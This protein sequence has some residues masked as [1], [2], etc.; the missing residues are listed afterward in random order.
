[1]FNVMSLFGSGKSATDLPGNRKQADQWLETLPENDLHGQQNAIV[2]L[3]RRLDAEIQNPHSD[4]VDTL[5]VIDTIDHHIQPLQETLTQQYL[6]SPRLAPQLEN[7]LWTAIFRYYDVASRLYLN[8]LH[9]AQSG[10]QPK[11]G[12]SGLAQKLCARGLYNLGNAFKLKFLR[13]GSPDAEMW[14]ILHSF[15]MSAETGGYEKRMTN[16]YSNHEYSCTSLYLRVEM[17]AMSHPGSLSPEQIE[18]IDKWLL[19][20]TGDISIDRNPRPGRHHYFIDL[21]HSH[22]ALP[23]GAT[24]YPDTC[25]GWD[26]STLILQLQRTRASLIQAKSTG[27]VDSANRYRLVTALEY[28]EKQWNPGHLGKL[29]KF[30]RNKSTRQIATVHGLADLCA[31]VHGQES[32]TDGVNPDTAAEIRYTETVD[33]QMYGFITEN[34]KQRNSQLLGSVHKPLPAPDMWDTENESQN[35]YLI[36]FPSQHNS[37]L[38]LGSLIGALDPTDHQWRVCV[39]RRLI[40]TQQPLSMAGIQV[41]TSSPMVLLLQPLQSESRSGETSMRLTSSRALLTTPIQND[42]FTLIL[43][44]S[45][46][47]KSRVYKFQISPTQPVMYFRLGRVLEKGDLWIHTEALL[48]QNQNPTDPTQG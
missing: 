46:Y 34:T 44:S 42:H 35:G 6:R 3:L 33:L 11:S 24:S 10:S 15:F 7:K 27:G 21:A 18:L 39:V 28:A 45:N 38:H 36:K 16:V 4:L 19:N 1:M 13:Y 25:R 5:E 47:A 22:G 2:D 43:D 30:P 37:W 12:H 26:M 8:C 14:T 32:E 20:A 9:K 31:V 48:I 29:R 17:L 41:I 23:V 40:R